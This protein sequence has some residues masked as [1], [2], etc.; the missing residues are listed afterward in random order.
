MKIAIISIFFVAIFAVQSF[1]QDKKV[2]KIQAAY[3]S[4]AYEKC[5]KSAEKY[6]A[7]NPKPA[8]PYF[9]ISFSYFELYRNNLLDDNLKNSAKFLSKGIGKEKGEVYVAE[10]FEKFN[11]IKDTLHAVANRTYNEKPQKS[12]PYY[13]FL[14]EIYNDTTLRY[15]E[16]FEDAGRPDAEIIKEMREGTLNQTDASGKKQGKWKKVYDNGN[17]A[18]EVTFKDDKPQGEMLRYHKSGVIQ[19]KLRFQP[20]G[21]TADAQLFD[22][23]GKKIAEGRYVGKIKTGTWNYFENDKLRRV[24]PYNQSGELNGKQII[25]YDNGKVYDEKN[26]VNGVENGTWAKYYADGSQMLLSTVKDGKL[27]GKFQKWHSN[28]NIETT[29]QYVNDVSDGKWVY[30]SDDSSQKEEIIYHNGVPENKDELNEKESEQYRKTL[31]DSKRLI[32][33]QDYKTN[34]EEYLNKSGK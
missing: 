17:V 29:G 34:P 2:E 19:A 5:I 10:Y 6:V 26:F 30:T 3:Q 31:E 11:E 22:E 28:G 25:Y 16:L 1:A 4:G 14:A 21:V 24:E 27:E 8:L 18:Y 9:M 12:K 15:R 23:F 13:K 20:D 7:E 33:P 32:D